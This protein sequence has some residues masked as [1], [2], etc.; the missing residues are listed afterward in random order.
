MTYRITAVNTIKE[1]LNTVADSMT[2]HF[3]FLLSGYYGPF[4]AANLLR[5]TV[6]LDRG[7]GSYTYGDTVDM[8]FI[9]GR[10]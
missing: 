1:I 9:Y 2:V 5:A 10:V 4:A 8:P 3:F 7:S 6:T